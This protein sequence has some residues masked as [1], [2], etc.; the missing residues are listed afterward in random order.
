MPHTGRPRAAWLAAIVA[1]STLGGLSCG[2]AGALR[3]SLGVAA[4]SEGFVD[5]RLQEE[6]LLQETCHALRAPVSASAALEHAAAQDFEILCRAVGCEKDA[7]CTCDAKT[8]TVTITDPSKLAGKGV[9]QVIGASFRDGSALEGAALDAPAAIARGVEKL[10]QPAEVLAHLSLAR[11]GLFVSLR[12]ADQAQGLADHLAASF[13]VFQGFA[14]P[15]LSRLAAEVVAIGMDYT[16]TH[17]ET[18]LGVPRAD[19]AREACAMHERLDPRSSVAAN[20]LTRAILRYAPDEERKKVS[21]AR[22]DCERIN[23][24]INERLATRSGPAR[25]V[26][27]E[28]REEVDPP[29]SKESTGLPLEAWLSHR[30]PPDAG[31]QPSEAELKHQAEALRASAD[32]CL[33]A[34]GDAGAVTCTLARV[35]PVASQ[36]Y[37]MSTPGGELPRVEFRDMERRLVAIE[38]ELGALR[39]G[40][41]GL[42]VRIAELEQRERAN[43]VDQRLYET[44]RLQ[45]ETIDRLRGQVAN[46]AQLAYETKCK[47]PHRQALEARKRLAGALGFEITCPRAPASGDEGRLVHSSRFKELALDPAE[48]CRTGDPVRLYAEVSFPA[49]AS[50]LACDEK[51]PHPFCGALAAVARQLSADDITRDASPR[52][53]R[54]VGRASAEPVATCLRG[55]TGNTMLAIAEKGMPFFGIKPVPPDFSHADER[56]QKALSFLRAHEVASILVEGAKRQLLGDEELGHHVDLVA[57]GTEQ[58]EFCLG[59]SGVDRRDCED[60]D[61][62]AWIE[63]RLDR[64]TFTVEKCV[65]E[66]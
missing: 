42:D 18:K 53:L 49:C 54:V 48:I 58:S 45:Q 47:E 33:Q 10:R 28:M 59:K 34:H 21:G 40:V 30:P 13:G 2:G 44:V 55:E 60:R 41:Q 8:R 11:A 38:E 4:F 35:L 37:A 24:E 61:R 39:R 26:C 25:D 32:G 7:G 65:G 5:A 15:L 12:L 19:F 57:A 14:R 66:R 20:V 64:Y 46:L 29:K 62:R 50:D 36:L 56:R 52:T 1:S 27:A 51:H 31:R 22:Q 17:V 3:A 9:L 23:H 63:L 43:Q 16:F 6:R